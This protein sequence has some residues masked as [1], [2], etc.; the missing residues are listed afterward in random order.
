[1][2]C[3]VF[4][5]FVYV[6]GLLVLAKNIFGTTTNIKIQLD[7]MIETQGFCGNKKYDTI[8]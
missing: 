7:Q 5:N 3:A 2:T 4:Y 1:M 6:M 8:N